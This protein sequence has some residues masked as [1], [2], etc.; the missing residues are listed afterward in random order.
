MFAAFVKG[1]VFSKCRTYW[2]YATSPPRGCFLAFVPESITLG[3]S[4]DNTHEFSGLQSIGIAAQKQTFMISR[5][6]AWVPFGNTGYP[7]LV[8]LS[9]KRP[10]A[11]APFA[12]LVRFT[13]CSC[14][15]RL[16]ES[17]RLFCLCCGLSLLILLP[18]PETKSSAELFSYRFACVG[19]LLCCWLYMKQ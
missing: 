2:L 14:A 8:E 1:L 12:S 5:M 13:T 4:C 10:G 7:F 11:S 3:C 17:E 16:G 19:R 18:N 6:N 15:R 9:S